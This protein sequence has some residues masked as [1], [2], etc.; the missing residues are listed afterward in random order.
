MASQIKAQALPKEPA[1]AKTK[2]ANAPVASGRLIDDPKVGAR[3]QKMLPA[4]TSLRPASVGFKSDMQFMSAVC[5]SK[6][7]GI[8]FARLKAKITGNHAVSMESAIRDLRR[9][10]SKAKAKAEAEKGMR[11]AIDLAKL[12]RPA[13]QGA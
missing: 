9:D 7:L 10:L 4:G 1:G 3:L 8:P 5:V 13:T 12:D 2:D 11:Q 6:H